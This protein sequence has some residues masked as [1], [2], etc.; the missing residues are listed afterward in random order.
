MSP[1][2]S[3]ITAIQLGDQAKS[4]MIDSVV[5]PIIAGSWTNQSKFRTAQTKTSFPEGSSFEH[6]RRRHIDTWRKQEL[7]EGESLLAY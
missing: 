3:T 7:R 6:F 1:R 2:D 5:L 4:R